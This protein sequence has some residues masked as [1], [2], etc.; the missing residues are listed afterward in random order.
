VDRNIRVAK[1][2]LHAIQGARCTSELLH[3][4]AG[5][6]NYFR[7]EATAYAAQVHSDEKLDS[8][9]CAFNVYAMLADQFPLPEAYRRAVSLNSIRVCS[10][11]KLAP[12]L[13]RL[14]HCPLAGY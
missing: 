5:T 13:I 1:F 11:S 8:W 2:G 6:P 7:P 3:M 10:L 4:L 9:A 12:K 14:P